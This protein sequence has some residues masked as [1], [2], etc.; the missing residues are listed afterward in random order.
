MLQRLL[1]IQ[2][3]ERK[4]MLLFAL[5]G[6]SWSIA[7]SS[8]AS[9]SDI[10]FLK[11]VGSESL[12]ETFLYTALGMFFMSW[13]FLYLYNRFEINQIF[14][15]SLILGMIIFGTIISL[16]LLGVNA[17]PLW[18][19]F[20]V[21]VYVFQI[22]YLSQYFT[23]LD[24]FF[25]LQNAK[26]V[27][28]ILYSPIFLGMCVAGAVLSFCFTSVGL[29][30]FLILI[31]FALGSSLFLLRYITQNV[32]KIPDDHQEFAVI[33]TSKKALFKAIITSPFTLLFV[34]GCILLH[35]LLV[36]TEYHYMMG[37]EYSFSNSDPEDL[38]RCLGNLYFWGSLINILFG[39]C[40]YGRIVKKIGLNNVILIVPLFFTTLFSGWLFSS[41]IF[42][43]IMGFIAVEGLLA[44]LEDNNF[45]LLLNAVPLKLKNKIRVTCESFFEPVGVFTSA[46]L[47]IFFKSYGRW[48][49]L[50][51]SVS[52]LIITTLMRAYYT[53][54]IFY[55]LI[56]HL[57]PFGQNKVDLKSKVSKKEYSVSKDQFLSKFY[58][59]KEGEQLFIIESAL[60]FHD[61]KLL[62]QLLKKVTKLSLTLKLSLFELFE[63]YPS[64]LTLKFISYFQ[65]WVKQDPSLE[66]DFFYFLSK[67]KLLEAQV[68]QSHLNDPC[69]KI[70]AASLLTIRQK[71]PYSLES[72]EARKI[73]YQLLISLNEEDNLIAI[74]ILKYERLKDFKSKVFDL[75]KT[76]SLRLKEAILKTLPYLLDSQDTQYAPILLR[77]LQ[78]DG[79]ATLR[80]LLLH[81]IGVIGDVFLIKEL[82]IRG[83]HFSVREKR[84][85]V[86]VVS[87]MGTSCIPE[88]ESIL[89]NTHLPDP[90]RLLAARVLGKISRRHLKYVFNKIWSTEM[91]RAYF[92]FYHYQTI[93]KSCLQTNL[94][95]LETTLKNSYD[96][97][98]KFIIETLALIH[99]FEQ[100]DYLV[101]SLLSNRPK[102]Y[103]HALETLD[104]IC[105]A[106]HY[107]RFTP[108]IEKGNEDDFIK[109]Y[110]KQKLPILTL[111]N[112]LDRLEQTPSYI[113]Q[114]IVPL[115]RNRYNIPSLQQRPISE[116]Y[117]KK[118]DHFTL[119]LLEINAL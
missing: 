77:H 57:I 18:I 38:S 19:T 68:A 21:F 108:L 23:F 59:M 111:D 14:R 115:F 25:E 4:S 20:K 81:V 56:S 84:V 98:F 92:Y 102:T 1:G 74:Q 36:L 116:P 49:G 75:L 47:L 88:L 6:F 60:R 67:M 107:K 62:E 22:A 101:K 100:G 113:N 29:F 26:R 2:P 82:L 65:F 71:I 80:P 90:I 94:T 30:G 91:D 83:G 96:S 35:S 10:L 104:K 55:N 58:E 33:K 43:P 73:L 17:K 41:H 61:L 54:G 53:K 51:F 5:L 11:N 27:F 28:S 103:S 46:M 105:N 76:S 48:I 109:L 3:N 16:I 78:E 87:K 64:P 9:V 95:L 106:K 112:L 110:H 12:A 7:S 63:N 37:L 79:F 32:P 69:P 45:N 40:I 70:K 34:S 72:K 117:N 15:T 97:V 93:H 31:L 13:I 114:M 52:F 118:L 66:Q 89:Q 8:C 99:H 24:Q 50:F 119:E 86:D 85:L 39:L 42:L 44:L